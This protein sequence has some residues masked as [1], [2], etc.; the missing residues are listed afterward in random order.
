M[1]LFFTHEFTRAMCVG[2]AHVRARPRTREF[3][4]PSWQPYRAHTLLSRITLFAIATPIYTCH[5]IFNQICIHDTFRTFP[6]VFGT[7]FQL[8][9]NFYK[10][11]VRY[12]F[13]NLSLIFLKDSF[14]IKGNDTICVYILKI[15]KEF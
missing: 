6:T 10:S 9:F 13:K 2:V 14:F 8:S 3:V 4:A 5:E 12:R 15:I 7:S 11:I 1:A